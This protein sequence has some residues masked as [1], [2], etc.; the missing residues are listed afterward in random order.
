MTN[1]LV[2]HISLQ[3]LASVYRAMCRLCVL[4]RGNCRWSVELEETTCV[5]RMETEHLTKT[6]IGELLRLAGF[7]GE[8]NLTSRLNPGPPTEE[9]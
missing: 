3:S 2:S 4:L 1:V 6:Q 8:A 5:L 7:D 9:A